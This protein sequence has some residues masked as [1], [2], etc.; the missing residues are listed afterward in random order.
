MSE[1]S[2]LCKNLLILNLDSLLIINLHVSEQDFW[3]PGSPPTILS[4]KY[5]PSKIDSEIIKLK[6]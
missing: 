3:F 1:W 6:L 5:S 4:P 2:V